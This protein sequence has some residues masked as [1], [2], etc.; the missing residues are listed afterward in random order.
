M[1]YAPKPTHIYLSVRLL[2]LTL[3]KYMSDK[4]QQKI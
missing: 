4:E 3:R 2:V 1:E